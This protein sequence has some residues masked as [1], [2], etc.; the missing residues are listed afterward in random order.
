MKDE[1]EHFP[2]ILLSDLLELLLVDQDHIQE[3]GIL[4]HQTQLGELVPVEISLTAIIRCNDI[5]VALLNFLEV[6]S[7]QSCGTLTSFPL[8]S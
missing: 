6:W 7:R 1:V 2:D 5:S 8:A 3:L 4:S